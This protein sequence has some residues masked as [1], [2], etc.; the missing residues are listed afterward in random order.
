MS[1]PTPE[2]ER[3]AVLALIGFALLAAFGAAASLALMGWLLSKA[4]TWVFG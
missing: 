3:K 1:L 2:Q 4:A